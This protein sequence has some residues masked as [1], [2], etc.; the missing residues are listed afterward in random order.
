MATTIIIII[1]QHLKALQY[2]GSLTYNPPWL[3]LCVTER[4]PCIDYLRIWLFVHLAA[5]RCWD[6]T[7]LEI[8]TGF[9]RS[10]LLNMTTSIISVSP[11]SRISHERN[12]TTLLS[13]VLVGNIS[14]LLDLSSFSC[15]W[16][17]LK[18]KLTTNK[19]D[20]D[21]YSL[22]AHQKYVSKHLRLILIS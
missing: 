7:K 2:S 1:I 20:K 11:S 9:S 12:H 22:H 19:T 6:T 8:P 3:H 16:N 15:F 10:W 5:F 4:S 18:Q 21:L 17:N 14:T 13:W